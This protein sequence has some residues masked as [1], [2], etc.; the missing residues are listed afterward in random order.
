[1]KKLNLIIL[2]TT[3]I[4]SLSLLFYEFYLTAL[5]QFIFVLVLFSLTKTIELVSDRPQ[6]PNEGQ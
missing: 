4:F 2:I 6:Q 3:F 5:C 1:M